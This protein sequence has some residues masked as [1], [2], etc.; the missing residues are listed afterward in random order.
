MIPKC[1]PIKKA[2]STRRF[3]F[4]IRINDKALDGIGNGCKQ[5]PVT[6][7]A[8]NIDKTLTLKYHI[9]QVNKHIHT[10]NFY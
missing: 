6:I 2:K 3:I 8:T 4:T 10:F 9:T 1:K 7:L 5:K